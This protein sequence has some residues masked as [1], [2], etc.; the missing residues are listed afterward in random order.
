MGKP[1]PSAR[2]DI[3]SSL[4][5]GVAR[6]EK[7]EKGEAIVWSRGARGKANACELVEVYGLAHRIARRAET[8]D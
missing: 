5:T 1:V 3:R 6:L 2:Q 7:H 4:P 8:S